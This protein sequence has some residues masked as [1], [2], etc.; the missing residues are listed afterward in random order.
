MLYNFSPSTSMYHFR[1]LRYVALMVVLLPYEFILTPCCHNCWQ[2]TDKYKVRF[3]KNYIKFFVLWK[4]FVWFKSLIL[5]YTYIHKYI[6]T[7]THAYIHTY[8]YTY[9]HTYILRESAL[10]PKEGKRARTKLR[11][12]SCNSDHVAHTVLR[13]SSHCFRGHQISSLSLREKPK[14]KIPLQE[15]LS[16]RPLSGLL[17]HF[18]THLRKLKLFRLDVLQ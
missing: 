8:I 16:Q 2:K 9:I 12:S 6:H 7:F 17:I 10:L 4:F 15:L 11:I 18:R 1:N 5:W 3:N 14:L 13:G